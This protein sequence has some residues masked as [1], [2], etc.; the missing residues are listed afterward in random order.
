MFTGYRLDLERPTRLRARCGRLTFG[1]G[2]FEAPAAVDHRRWLRRENQG[3]M[4][5]CRGFTRSTGAEIS[6]YYATKGRVMQFSPMWC[7][8]RCQAVDRLLGRD[9]GSTIESGVHVAIQEGHC[10]EEVFPYPNP[11]RYSTQIPRGAAEAAALYKSA[12]A[13]WI[14]DVEQG[15]AFLGGCCGAIDMGTRWPLPIGRDRV[16]RDIS[17]AG[18]YGHAWSWCGYLDEKDDQGKPL[19]LGFNSHN[20]GFFFIT[21]RAL[22]QLLRRPDTSAVG[23]SH[24]TVPRPAPYDFLKEGI[25]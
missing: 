6:A 25:I 18:P 9:Q 10:P 1:L 16:L 5:S 20:D 19:S 12:S 7:Y 14:E 3:P 13:T 23:I 4:G 22:V 8:L 21:F 15:L 17:Y 11:V 2:D 24:M